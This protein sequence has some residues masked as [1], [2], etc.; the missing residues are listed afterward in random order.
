MKSIKTFGLA[1]AAAGAVIALIGAGSAM[2]AHDKI[3]VCTTNTPILCSVANRLKVPAGGSIDTL[4]LAVG[5]VIKGTLTEKCDQ[6][7]TTF[8]TEEEE[9]E[10]LNGQITFLTFT[11]NCSPCAT[12][13]VLNAPYTAKLAISGCTFGVTCKFEG[14]A[15]TLLGV[16]AAEGAEFK[17]EEEELKQTGGSAFFCGSTGKWTANYKIVSRGFIKQR[18]RA[19]KRR[20]RHL[21]AVPGRL[22]RTVIRPARKDRAA[23]AVLFGRFGV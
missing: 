15:V 10:V 1:V 8:K 19:H 4:L 5:V 23:G 22:G 7:L 18:R 12:V 9:K 17:A 2:A 11:G 16:N 21:L 3:A 14:T 13:K 20:Q 6:S